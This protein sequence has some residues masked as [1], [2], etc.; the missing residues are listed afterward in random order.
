[1][2]PLVERAIARLR[3]ALLNLTRPPTDLV[4]H[5]DHYARNWAPSNGAPTLG[6]E[7]KNEQGFVAALARAV[8]DLAAAGREW[9]ALELGAGGGRISL[10]FL[11]LEN[12]RAREVVLADPSPAM[13]E[14]CR[15]NLGARSRVRYAKLTGVD[16]DQFSDGEFDLVYS[17]D[18]FVHFEDIDV[19]NQLRDAARVLKP[20]GIFL[21]SVHDPV[22]Q[23]DYFRAVADQHR[24]SVVGRR[25]PNR[26]RF[27]SQDLVRR[28]AEAA[29]F[30]AVEVS[31]GD[32][33]I[34]RL[35]RA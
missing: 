10:E 8:D 7:W 3:R 28:A 24:R 19:F 25:G 21:V 34:Y 1:M 9:R 14:H 4:A 23:F 6:R 33:A 29:G 26:V 31:F 12:G 16:L 13:L 17:H 18:V 35:T 11:R 27:V 22:A 15:K 30:G 5:W 20:G 2:A 32:F